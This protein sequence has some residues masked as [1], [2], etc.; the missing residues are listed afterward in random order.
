MSFKSPVPIKTA[1]NIAA[2]SDSDITM[3]EGE[4]EAGL[5][6]HDFYIP[7][8]GK[9]TPSELKR[10]YK[11]SRLAFYQDML[12][13]GN[14]MGVAERREHKPMFAA[15]RTALKR[16]DAGKTRVSSVTLNGTLRQFQILA[17]KKDAAANGISS[18][19]KPGTIGTVKIADA[20]AIAEHARNEEQQLSQ[21][22][23][24]GNSNSGRTIK[25]EEGFN[26]E[27]A[28]TSEGEFSAQSGT[29]YPNVGTSYTRAS[30]YARQRYTTQY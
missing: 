5:S 8:P 25:G 18:E 21:Q 27:V 23:S 7:P 3:L 24:L 1:T 26:E 17:E 20:K 30:S 29:F 15:M 2:Q 16:K 19:N 14:D 28:R 4:Y 12:N 22:V 13:Q 11:Q 10:R 6:L 9:K